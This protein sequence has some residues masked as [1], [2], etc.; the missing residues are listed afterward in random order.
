LSPP[1][2]VNVSASMS[3]RS[4]LGNDVGG[5][6]PRETTR[7]GISCRMFENDQRVCGNRNQL[8]SANRICLSVGGGAPTIQPRT[9]GSL[10]CASSGA[11]AVVCA[12]AGALP[13]M[14]MHTSSNDAAGGNSI[15]FKAGSA[16]LASAHSS[17]G[18]FGNP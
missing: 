10:A 13:A 16:D 17:R 3:A 7:V 4:A 12:A 15:L 18:R 11:A 2:G 1:V 5:P 6:P 14:T 9:R 8:P